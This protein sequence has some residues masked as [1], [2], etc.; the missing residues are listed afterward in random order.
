ME[1]TINK[2]LEVIQLSNNSLTL[3][4]TYTLTFLDPCYYNEDNVITT[5]GTIDV[6]VDANT[7]TTIELTFIQ[8]GQYTLVLDNSIDI[9]NIV[10]YREYELVK[11]ITKQMLNYICDKSHCNCCN[12]STECNEKDILS[13]I[14][15]KFSS[16]EVSTNSSTATNYLK[17]IGFLK[18]NFSSNYCN[19]KS[20]ILQSILNRTLLTKAASK[21]NRKQL[22]SIVL[23]AFYFYDVYSESFTEDQ[24]NSMYNIIKFKTCF[25]Y[26]GYDIESLQEQYENI[27]T[28]NLDEDLE[29]SGNYVTI[30]L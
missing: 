18:K 17:F 16:L 23:L 20:T 13:Y 14:I 11:N 7:P 2:K 27:N 30:L 4:I 29:S 26:L 24:L 5:T 3:P 10:I 19:F 22:V 8:D 28:D 9:I 12:N 21:N 25:K 6:A 15:Y 1:Y